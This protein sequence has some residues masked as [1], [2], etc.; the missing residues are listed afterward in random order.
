MFDTGSARSRAHFVL[1]VVFL[2]F[3]V[4]AAGS[5]RGRS[6]GDVDLRPTVALSIRVVNNLAIP[7]VLEVLKD[8]VAIWRGDIAASTSREFDAGSERV[9]TRVTLLATGS[10]GQVVSFRRDIPVR[11]GVLVWT[12]P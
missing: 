9:D 5:C 4:G 12:I 7:L 3:A 1:C 6:G 2:V 8:S 10:A 11:A